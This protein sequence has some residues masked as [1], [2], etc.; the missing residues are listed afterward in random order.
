MNACVIAQL[1]SCFKSRRISGVRGLLSRYLS[2]H[3]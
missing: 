1:G 3:S 2:D